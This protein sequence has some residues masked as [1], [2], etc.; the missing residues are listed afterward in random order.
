MATNYFKSGQKLTAA[1]LN[2][3][4]DSIAG[5][6]N[7][8][9]EYKWTQTSLGRMQSVWDNFYNTK[10]VNPQPLDVEVSIEALQQPIELSG[11]SI[12]G[13]RHVFINT[14]QLQSATIVGSRGVGSTLQIGR[15]NWMPFFGLIGWQLHYADAIKPGDNKAHFSMWSEFGNEPADDTP[16]EWTAC[17]K[18][19]QLDVCRNSSPNKWWWSGITLE[20][21]S[22]SMLSI[23][24]MANI[25]AY[26]LLVIVRPK[27]EDMY[28]GLLT[29]PFLIMSTQIDYLMRYLLMEETTQQAL[30]DN[31]ETYFGNVNNYNFDVEE[32]WI[33]DDP[34]LVKTVATYTIEKNTQNG[35]YKQTTNYVEF[36]KDHGGN[37]ITQNAG[38]AMDYLVDNV[39]YIDSKGHHVV[40]A[41]APFAVTDLSGNEIPDIS[42]VPAAL[43]IAWDYDKEEA[44]L[45]CVSCDVMTWQ[46]DN[47][48]E[49]IAQ[50]VLS[51]L[52]NNLSSTNIDKRLIWI[53]QCDATN[54]LYFDTCPNFNRPET[55]KFHFAWSTYLSGS[56]Q[57]QVTVAHIGEGAIQ[58]GGYSYFSDGGDVQDVL[59]GTY[60]V[61][62]KC[63]LGTSVT[64]EFEKYN[65]LS[66]LNA[67]QGDLTKYI[68]PL[69]KI[70]DGEVVVDYRPM[71]NAGCWEIAESI[72]PVVNNG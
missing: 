51:S 19:Y 53:D 45:S 50:Y 52:F 20:N 66:A 17:Q 35:F 56:S 42:Y 37:K 6:Q 67:A 39:Q 28:N 9:D 65:D 22:K 71:P 72:R 34:F 13:V 38:S 62:A 69:Y 2:G 25:V 70:N 21:M 10:N 24:T 49:N 26:P 47:H 12:N 54:V 5:I 29:I 63:N 32:M 60:Y 7:P 23:P 31:I 16:T 41:F 64:I 4:L 36:R 61:C 3:A 57:N 33:P 44:V 68:F 46:E 55:T 30:K 48:D 8:S 11:Q 58:I 59:S 15:Y 27:S 43:A 14:G 40:R 18:L 1:D